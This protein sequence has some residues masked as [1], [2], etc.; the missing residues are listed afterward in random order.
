MT[1]HLSLNTRNGGT[2]KIQCLQG[3]E[4]RQRHVEGN[5]LKSKPR[6]SFMIC[7]KPVHSPTCI[8]ILN[9][10]HLSW[11]F[12]TQ[13]SRQLPFIHR[14]ARSQGIFRLT[15]FSCNLFSSSC[16]YCL[17]KSGSSHLLKSIPPKCHSLS[18]FKPC[19]FING[20]VVNLVAWTVFLLS[21]FLP[22]E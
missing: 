17:L 3:Q 22:G 7:Q 4:R 13:F 9:H 8:L 5:K 14:S 2:T 18:Y 21:S 19:A 10:N 1:S 11:L 16:P 12:L 15:V 20:V 6:S